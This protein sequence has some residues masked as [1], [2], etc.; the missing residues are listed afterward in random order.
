MIEELL[1]ISKQAGQSI[2]KIYKKH[3]FFN[4]KI[5]IKN[6]IDNSPVT[7]ADILSHNIIYNNLVKL[8]PDIPVISEESNINSLLNVKKKNLYWLVDPLD[9][10]KEFINKN[11]EF[12][13]NISLIKNGNPIIGVIYVPFFNVFYYSYKNESWIINSNNCRKKI[14]VKKKKIVTVLTSRSHTD[15]KINKYLES[16]PYDKIIK[17]G[18]SLKFCHLAEGKA[19]LYPRFGNIHT[20]DIA[21]GHSILLGAKGYLHSLSDDKKSINYSLTGNKSDF[22]IKTGFI[23]SSF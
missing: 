12:T 3:L 7:N 10:T 23:A 21:A 11:N 5:T 13:V 16:I 17:I 2:L 22:L 4:N 20:W 1:N 6:K 19:Q 8:Y 9:G 15:K 18:S 14:F